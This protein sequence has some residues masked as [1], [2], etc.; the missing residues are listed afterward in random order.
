VAGGDGQSAAPQERFEK[1]GGERGAFGGIR[2]RAEFVEQDKA[3]FAGV[4]QHFGHAARMGGEGVWRWSRPARRRYRPEI[5]ENGSWLS[6][7]TGA[8]TPLCTS[9]ATRPMVLSNVVLPPRWGR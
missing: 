3:V 6:G 5:G 4:A 1:S 2:G 7:E 9:A 8:G